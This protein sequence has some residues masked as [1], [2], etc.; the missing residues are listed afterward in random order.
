METFTFIYKVD[1]AIWN[2]LMINYSTAWT[3]IFT[4]ISSRLSEEWTAETNHFLCYPGRITR[5]ISACE[6]ASWR[7]EASVYSSRAWPLRLAWL[8][9]L[10]WPCAAASPQLRLKTVPGPGGRLGGGLS[11][12]I[13]DN[14]RIWMGQHF[15]QCILQWMPLASAVLGCSSSGWLVQYRQ[16]SPPPLTA[17][18]NVSACGEPES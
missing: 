17:A 1:V 5:F 16:Y 8:C 3:I 14:H 2:I 11:L 7:Q 4:F 18:I 6:V 12:D 13:P 9:G 15:P 10:A